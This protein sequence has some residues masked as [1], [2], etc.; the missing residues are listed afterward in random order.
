MN[1]LTAKV[2]HIENIESLHSLTFEL[3][4]QV[5]HML[6]L[7]LDSSLKIGDLI[8][9]NVKST[10]IAIGKEF[11]GLLS[12]DNQLKAKV[13]SVNNGQV[14]SSIRVNFEGFILESI[15]GVKASLK[16]EIKEGDDVLVLFRGSEVSLF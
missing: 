5:I 16:M 6:S 2:I 14:L 3:N 11:L 7:E 15:I 9:L 13:K 12:Y 8:T 10:D 4:Q 1:Q